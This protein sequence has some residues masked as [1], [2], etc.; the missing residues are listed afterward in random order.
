MTPGQSHRS[1]D[2]LGGTTKRYAN[3]SESEK[4]ATKIY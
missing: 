4:L 3:K 2:M 1:A